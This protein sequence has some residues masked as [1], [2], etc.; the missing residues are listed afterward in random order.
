MGHVEQLPCSRKVVLALAFG[1]ESVAADAMESGGEHVDEK[2]ADELVGG[3]RILPLEG[4]AVVDGND[5][6]EIATRWV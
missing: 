4:N 1:Q 3:E 2:A 6:L 5:G